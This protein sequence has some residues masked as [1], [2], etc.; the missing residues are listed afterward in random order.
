MRTAKAAG[1]RGTQNKRNHKICSKVSFSNRQALK[2][3]RK[4]KFRWHTGAKET[5]ALRW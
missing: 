3:G 4:S 1:K 2:P 5:V